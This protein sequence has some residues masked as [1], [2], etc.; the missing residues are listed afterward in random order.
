MN[1]EHAWICPLS[2][3]TSI[4][5]RFCHCSPRFI[6]TTH[7]LIIRNFAV[8]VPKRLWNPRRQPLYLSSQ[9][10]LFRL[11]QLLGTQGGNA[12]ISNCY[13]R[14]ITP[15]EVDSCAAASPHARQTKEALERC[16]VI[17]V[18]HCYPLFSTSAKVSGSMPSFVL[19]GDSL[20]AGI[21]G[22]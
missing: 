5:G 4:R 3:E 1:I 11:R 10:L 17:R 20:H 14:P 22:N 16:F 12:S 15:L 18:R 13:S 21:C 19:I 9:F 8:I 2:S 6:G 7:C